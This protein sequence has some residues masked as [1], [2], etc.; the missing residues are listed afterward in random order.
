MPTDRAVVSSGRS[1][2]DQPVIEAL[3]IPLAMTVLDEFA[4][5]PTKVPFAYRNQSIQTL[6]FDRS[7][8]RSAWAFAFGA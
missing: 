4:E 5:R 2:V 1:P 7:H 6:F 8:E 3:M